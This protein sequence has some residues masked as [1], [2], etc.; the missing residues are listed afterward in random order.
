MKKLWSLLPVGTFWANFYI[1]YE[2]MPTGNV[3]PETLELAVETSD[4]G[5]TT[6]Q[7]A[8]FFD[9]YSYTWF[10]FTPLFCISVP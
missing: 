5:S 8:F 2:I 4:V 3:G 7:I 9:G 10:V 1:G 6:F